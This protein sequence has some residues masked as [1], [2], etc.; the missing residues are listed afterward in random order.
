MKFPQH[1]LGLTNFFTVVGWLVQEL[2]DGR[3]GSIMSHVNHAHGW[4]LPVGCDLPG[5]VGAP[6]GWALVA[7]L[8][9]L[10]AL[11]TWLAGASVEASSPEGSG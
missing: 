6:E 7:M 1:G 5:S 4:S 9:P 11:A 3:K 8:V 2:P 10:L